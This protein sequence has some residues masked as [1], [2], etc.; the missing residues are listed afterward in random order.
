MY[1]VRQLKTQEPPLQV[2]TTSECRSSLHGAWKEHG[3]HGLHAAAGLNGDW[4]GP[5]PP[6]LAA[7]YP[8][9]SAVCTLQRIRIYAVYTVTIVP[10][11]KTSLNRTDV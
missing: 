1:A 10:G 5:T 7:V 3:R 9:E 6:A 4:N 8:P 11:G 2:I